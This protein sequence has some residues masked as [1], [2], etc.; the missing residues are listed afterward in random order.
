VADPSPPRDPLAVR[1]RSLVERYFDFVWRS[2][3]RLGFD[4][5]D[6]DDLTQDVFVI[7]SRRLA[8]VDPARE[9]A[10][11]FGTLLRVSATRRR[12]DGRR[13]EDLSDTDDRHGALGLDPEQ[14]SE[15]YSARPLLDEI[16]EGLPEAQRVVFVL[17]ELEE[18]EVAEIAEL[19]LAPAGTVASRL[20]AARAAFQAAASRLRARESNLLR[21]PRAKTPR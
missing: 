8:S 19:V 6:A 9:R 1:L 20:K 14:L 15:L 13:R 11:L 17:Y 10:F 3:R 16:L 12:G 2:A 21:F 4:H 7:A 5:A 18:L